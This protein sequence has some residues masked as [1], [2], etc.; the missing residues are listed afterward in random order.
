MA[1]PTDLDE[2]DRELASFGKGEELLQAVLLRAREAAPQDLPGV[3]AALAELGVATDALVAVPT[4]A[5]PR[6]QTVPPNGARAV[7]ATWAREE[8]VEP[9]PDD[10]SGLVEVPEEVLRSEALPPVLELPDAPLARDARASAADAFEDTTDIRD[11]NSLEDEIL[12]DG[13]PESDEIITGE[14]ALD[15]PSSA[16]DERASA[17]AKT[18]DDAPLAS[19]FD[20]APA[21]DELE[22]AAGSGGLADLFDDEDLARPEAEPAAHEDLADLLSP[23]L[24]SE[25]AAAGQAHEEEP[26]QTAIFTSDE[27]RALR[28]SAAPPRAEE[29]A[30]DEQLD[31]LVSDS[32]SEA[33]EPAEMPASG[34]FELMIDEDVL[35]LDDDGD[36]EVEEDASAAGAGADEGSERPPGS[37]SQPPP[38]GF[39]SRILNRK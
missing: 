14:V 15:A 6:A 8:R 26:E 19:L 1:S 35:V 33:V 28:S 29:R 9:V 2:I 13:A 36:L 3:D 24:Q 12:G 31:A 25:L 38:K 5:R 4:E 27:V 18:R 20:D 23:E 17:S 7:P 11:P 32:L 30:M 16:P 21:P 39:F 10:A 22:A 34:D 37:P